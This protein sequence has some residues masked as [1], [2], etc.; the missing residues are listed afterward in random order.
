MPQIVVR[1]VMARTM[2]EG[3]YSVKASA[4][5]QA[6]NGPVNADLT[7]PSHPP[8]YGT[9]ANAGRRLGDFMRILV[10]V[11]A[12]T[13]VLLGAGSANAEKRLFIIANNPDAYGVDRC[14]TTGES[15]GKT[16]AA[17]YCHSHEYQQALSFQK[18]DRDDITGA[19]PSEGPEACRGSS[20]NYVAIEC[21][22]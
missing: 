11:T 15:C 9:Q 7:Q 22:R 19:I 21:S 6:R 20:C 10:A 13:A 4:A 17:S 12:M 18:V 8:A 5:F 2:V 1:L 3:G 16:V 14:L